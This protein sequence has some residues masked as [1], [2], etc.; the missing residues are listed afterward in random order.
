MLYIYY[1]LIIVKLIKKYCWHC[2][3]FL[4]FK[5]SGGRTLS[6]P[7]P[8]RERVR[9]RE[10]IVHLGKDA[11][12]KEARGNLSNWLFKKWGKDDKIMR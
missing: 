12:K 8:L 10:K 6:L 2:I 4:F 11:L 1:T 5:K 7:S 9:V 3:L